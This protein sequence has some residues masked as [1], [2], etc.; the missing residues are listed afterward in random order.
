MKERVALDLAED[1]PNIRLEFSLTIAVEMRARYHVDSLIA[2]WRML[3]RERPCALVVKLSTEVRR[4]EE[5]VGL[6]RGVQHVAHL[7]EPRVFPLMGVGVGVDCLDTLH[8]LLPS[9]R[10]RAQLGLV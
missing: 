3:T 4:D 2:P 1:S 6:A 8:Q 10:D 9:A 7:G 5:L